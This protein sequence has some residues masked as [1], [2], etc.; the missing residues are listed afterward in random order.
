MINDIRLSK[1]FDWWDI[2]WNCYAHNWS[3]QCVRCCQRFFFSFLLLS[4]FSGCL[5]KTD[6]SLT[7]NW[8]WCGSRVNLLQLDDCMIN[9]VLWYNG[10]MCAIFK[11]KN[12]NINLGTLPGTF[13]SLSYWW[14]ISC[15]VLS[16]LE[17][18]C[19]GIFSHK[20]FF[21]YG[22][23]DQINELSI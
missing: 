23:H 15:W 12:F 13:F 11:S 1:N 5:T 4:F 6:K 9:V 21:V 16:S 10:L 3:K 8:W 19:I 17:I 2:N 22:I 18:A 7:I 20:V 14:T